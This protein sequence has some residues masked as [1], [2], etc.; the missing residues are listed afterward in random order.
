LSE[1]SAELCGHMAR[2]RI[3]SLEPL[4][5]FGGMDIYDRSFHSALARERSVEL[6]WATSDQGVEIHDDGNVARSYE[7]WTPFH[8]VFGAG[9]LVA[10]GVRYAR[11]LAALVQRAVRDSRRQPV[12]VHQ[13]FIA[14]PPLELAAMTAAQRLGVPWILTPH[15]ALPYSGSRRNARFRRRM[16]AGADALVAL[17]EANRTE[18]AELARVPISRVTLTP[19]G[20]LNDYR[21][22]HANIDSAKARALLGLE[23]HAPT[24]LFLGEMRRVKG[25]EYL[26]RAMPDVLRAIPRARLVI[27]GRPYRF[28][29]SGPENLI[30]SLGVRH[31][32]TTRWGFVPKSD[33]GLYLRASDVVALPYLAASQSAA[34]FTAYAYSRAVVASCVGGLVEQVQDGIT[35]L[36]VPPADVGALAEA[37]IRV[38]R[39]PG[40]SRAMGKAAHD[41]ASRERDWGPVAREHI[42]VY[43]DAWHARHP[44]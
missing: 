6:T 43:A 16:F 42:R 14:V 11:G 1:D 12:V 39:E 30:E 17:S 29:S 24:V 7:T 28:D 20:H 25:L 38:L 19:L 31:A 34:C 5:S 4:G 21:G 15:E 8:R 27:A 33:L 44:L 26:L 23:D 41:W 37:L 32:V 18:L 9:S 36:L 40:T 35:G 10:Q 3:F 13:Q 2:M 22:E